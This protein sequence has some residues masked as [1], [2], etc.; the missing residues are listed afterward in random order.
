MLRS[1][2]DGSRAVFKVVFGKR[3]VAGVAVW[4]AIVVG[5]FSWMTAHAATPGTMN[6][7]PGHW[8]A[9]SPALDPALPTLVLFAHPE[10]PCTRASLH[11]LEWVLARTRGQVRPYVVFAKPPGAPPSWERSTLRAMA[12]AIPGVVVVD[13]SGDR[14]AHAFQAKTSGDVVVYRPTG[15]LAFA[16][17]ITDGRGHEG[18]NA[19]RDALFDLLRG[20]TSMSE[21]ILS[22][23]FGCPIEAPTSDKR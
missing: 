11:E 5:G 22:R 17:G 20:S 8:P 4:A 3:W 15:E 18:A 7:A 19:S 14:L 23:V 6:D 13:D 9:T 1:E 10:C 21:R 16:G 12:E 2:F